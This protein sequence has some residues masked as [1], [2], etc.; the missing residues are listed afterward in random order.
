MVIFEKLLKRFSIK[1]PD[2]KT[3][4]SLGPAA[5][6]SGEKDGRLRIMV[7]GDSNAYRPGNGSGSW[8]AILQRISGKT[9]WVINESCDGRTT[10]YDEGPCNGLK[11]IEKKIRRAAPLDYVIIALGTNDIKSKYGP[12]DAAEVVMGIDGLVKIIKKV[13]IGIQPLLLTPP[14]LGHVTTGDLA[15]A[16]DRIPPLVAEYHRYTSTNNI[17]VI[18]LYLAV[19]KD[20]DLEPDRIHLNVQGRRKVAATLWMNLNRVCRHV[21]KI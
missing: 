1:I 10:R 17:P 8:P 18:D 20:F 2:R 12:P 7:F 13:H 19:D 6:I 4:E 3:A 5:V 11:V 14:P 21:G 9:L 15:G 16:Q